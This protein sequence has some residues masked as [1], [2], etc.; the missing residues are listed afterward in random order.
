MVVF[1]FALVFILA[2]VVVGMMLVA[3]FEYKSNSIENRVRLNKAKKIFIITAIIL[4]VLFVLF[5]VFIHLL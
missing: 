4:T 1:Y 5:T 2:A 3:F